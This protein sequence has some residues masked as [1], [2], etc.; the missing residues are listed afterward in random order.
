MGVTSRSGHHAYRLNWRIAGLLPVVSLVLVGAEP[1]LRHWL[2]VPVTVCGVLVAVD[3]V[4]WFRRR[5]DVFDPRA[6]IGLFGLHFFYLAPVLHVLLDYW[7]PEGIAPADWRNALG[8][9]AVVNAVGLLIYRGVLAVRRSGRH[10]ARPVRAVDEPVLHGAGRLA[11]VVGVCAFIGE[12]VLFGGVAGYLRTA[13]TDREAFAGLGWLLIIGDS[14]P[15]IA[16]VSIVIRWRAVLARRRRLLGLLLA[17]MVVTQ[18]VV[19]GLRGSRTNFIWPVLVAVILIHLL[20]VPVT[21]RALGVS[22]LALGVFLYG[23]GLY[24]GSGPRVLDIV[25]GERTIAQV[26]SDSN[27]DLPLV[28][29]GDLGRADINARMLDRLRTGGASPAYGQTYLAGPA[30]LVPRFVLPKRPRDKVVIGTDIIYGPGSYAAGA[31]SSRAYGITG[32]AIMNFGIPGGLLSFAGLA[33]AVRGVRRYY[34]RARRGSDLVT[35]LLAPSL[36][37]LAVNLLLWDFANI[38][39]FVVKHLG[40]LAAVIALAIVCDRRRAAPRLRRVGDGLAVVGATGVAVAGAPAGAL[41]WRVR[42]GALREVL[43]R[44]GRRGP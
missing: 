31:R 19:A 2:M 7:A 3:A 34:L 15:L 25:R 18:F 28:L 32:E 39:W 17:G 30:L 21:R 27:R 22:A 44:A 41:R 1:R 20:V 40:P 10:V 43:R 12:L 5:T 36:C 16:F 13:S 29:L 8:R 11:V 42:T 38:V 6:L 37:L 14:F 24:K 4:E 35:V 23:Y 26:S 9:L 33:L